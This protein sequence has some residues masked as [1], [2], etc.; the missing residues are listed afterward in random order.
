MSEE[1][2][3]CIYMIQ[4]AGGKLVDCYFTNGAIRRYDVRK[5]IKLGG[6]F[7]P[8]KDQALF[9]RSAMVMDG[10]LAFDIAGTRDPYSVVDICADVIY[11]EGEAIEERKAA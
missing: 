10:V 7:A 6:V 5:A 1:Y 11:S 2:I 4:L 9:E 3:P 8:L